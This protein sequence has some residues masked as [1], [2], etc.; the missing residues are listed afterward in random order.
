MKRS[1]PILVG[2]VLRAFSGMTPF[3]NKHLLS[4]PEQRQEDKTIGDKTAGGKLL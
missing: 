1:T 2:S 4:H 3:I